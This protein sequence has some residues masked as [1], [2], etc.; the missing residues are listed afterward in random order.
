MQ[1]PLIHYREA[2]FISFS[3][4]PALGTI[5]GNQADDLAEDLETFIDVSITKNANCDHLVV[6]MCNERDH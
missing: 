3:S 2:A 4:W 5:E 1:Y 6:L